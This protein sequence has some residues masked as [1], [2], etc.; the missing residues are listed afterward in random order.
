M[1]LLCFLCFKLCIF[2]RGDSSKS[3]S[4]PRVNEP[5]TV[6]KMLN[7]KKREE[8]G[9]GKGKERWYFFTPLPLPF[10]PYFALG[11]TTTTTTATT[12]LLFS[13][14]HHHHIRIV[15]PPP[16]P[17]GEIT[18]KRAF[19]GVTI[20]EQL[21]TKTRRRWKPISIPLL[22]RRTKKRIN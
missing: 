16:F 3:F 22:K 2:S 10:F 1:F 7:C 19:V 11:L 20:V 15:F 18:W 5:A 12:F 6:T 13:L 8:L 17:R 9:R 14:H 4:Y 21:H